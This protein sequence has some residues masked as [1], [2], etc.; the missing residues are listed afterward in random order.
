MGHRRYDVDTGRT[1]CYKKMIEDYKLK[2]LSFEQYRTILKALNEYY[3]NHMMDTGNIVIFP[4]GMGK[5]GIDKHKRV[6]PRI[7]WKA[8]M[9]SKDGKVVYHTYDH[10]DGYSYQFK[11][12]KHD[13]RIGI[14][15]MWR[16]RVAKEV[17]RTLSKRLLDPNNQDAQK[18]RESHYR[19]GTYKLKKILNAS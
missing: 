11:W 6:R 1:D 7:N 13:S 12:F 18:Y 15:E 19:R 10:T 5:M 2:D 9:E 17:S 14:R 16:L 8:T 3:I 4:C